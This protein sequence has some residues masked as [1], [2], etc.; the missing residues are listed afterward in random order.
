MKLPDG[1]IDKCVGFGCDF[2]SI[3]CINLCE[4]KGSRCIFLNDTAHLYIP[5]KN[6]VRN[7]EFPIY[8]WE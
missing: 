2:A 5:D 8:P 1:D 6:D 4:D 3:G 7:L